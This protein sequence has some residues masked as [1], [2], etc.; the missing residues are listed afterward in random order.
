V[1]PLDE[2]K[3]KRPL[4]I[5]YFNHGF[6]AANRI[7]LR[8]AVMRVGAV[9]TLVI[10]FDFFAAYFALKRRQLVLLPKTCVAKPKKACSPRSQIILNLLTTSVM[11]A[12][13]L[14]HAYPQDCAG[15]GGGLPR[16]ILLPQ[17]SLLLFWKKY[18]AVF[19]T[20]KE[21]EGKSIC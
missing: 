5:H 19:G 3:W 1:I 10:R 14:T 12:Q 13:S 20:E 21:G 15:W 9:T 11:V 7:L 18:D 4:V 6:P 2:R 16:Q 17:P 8:M